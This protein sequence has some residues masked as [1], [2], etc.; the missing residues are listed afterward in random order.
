MRQ[1]LCYEHLMPRPIRIEYDG[2]WYHV[3]NRGARRYFVFH[4]HFDRKFF[5]NLLNQIKDLWNVQTHAYSL[6]GNH[7]HLLLHTP[8]SHLSVAMQHLNGLYTQFY[9]RKYKKDGPLFRGRFKSIL[10]ERDAYLIE[11]IR[12]IHLNPVKAGLCKTPEQHMWTSHMAYLNPKKRPKWLV[13]DDVLSEFGRSYRNAKKELDLFVKS[14]VPADLEKVFIAK[15]RISILG[16]DGFK[17]WIKYNF[18]DNVKKDKALVTIRQK[19]KKIVS[20][21]KILRFLSN[22]YLVP[23]RKILKVQPGRKNE[24]RSMAIYLLRHVNGFSHAKI[25]EVMDEVSKVSISKCLLRF[26]HKAKQDKTLREKCATYLDNLSH[27]AA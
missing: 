22:Q 15:K 12:Y 3:M 27:V 7:Y 4:D 23:K 20:T 18:L 16:S 14:G 5:L 19:K 17:D 26:Q 2:A 21:Q 11:L 25:A 24:A 10:A 1:V 6:M 9:N 13:V 8:N